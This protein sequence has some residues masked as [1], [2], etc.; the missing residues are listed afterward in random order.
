ML[1]QA[2]EVMRIEA[3]AIFDPDTMHLVQIMKKRRERENV[4]N[5]VKACTFKA[6]LEKH[7]TKWVAASLTKF[8][9]ARRARI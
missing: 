5:G 8:V 9:I 1:K 7:S 3:D 6:V 2:K 4:E